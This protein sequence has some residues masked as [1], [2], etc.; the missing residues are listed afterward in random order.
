M[1]LAGTPALASAASSAS[2][3]PAVLVLRCAARSPHLRTVKYAVENELQALPTPTA[4]V[5]CLHG[6]RRAR[7]A[8][9]PEGLLR[10][11]VS[12]PCIPC[13]YSRAN[14]VFSP[15]KTKHTG[16]A[17]VMHTQHACW[18]AVAPCSHA[19]PLAPTTT[20]ARDGGCCTATIL[21]AVSSTL[22]EGST[23]R[24][25]G[26]AAEIFPT[27]PRARSSTSPPVCRRWRSCGR[28]NRLCAI[29]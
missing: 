10:R 25:C 21:S 17:F 7:A 19:V 15:L 22:G 2:S 29:F 8:A 28:A 12:Q 5:L 13:C 6:G 24:G 23:V 14:I 16:D 1:A 3:D 4:V 9:P 20:R 11:Y 18:N 26:G 27:R